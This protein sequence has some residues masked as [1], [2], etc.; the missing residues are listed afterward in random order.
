MFKLAACL[1]ATASAEVRGSLDAQVDQTDRV[2]APTMKPTAFP[3][4]D[5]AS[6]FGTTCTDAATGFSKP[7]GWVGPGP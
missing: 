6:E 2:A 3:T 7:V 5:T 4:K 1:V